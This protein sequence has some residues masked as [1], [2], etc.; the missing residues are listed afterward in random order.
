M[1]DAGRKDFSTKAKEEITPDSTKSTQQKI[2]EGVT[3]TTDRVARGTQPDSDKSAGQSAFDK[4]QRS[5]DEHVH[6][7]TGQSMGRSAHS[8]ALEED[9]K[10]SGKAYRRSLLRSRDNHSTAKKVESD[11]VQASASPSTV[12]PE[13]APKISKSLLSH[14]MSSPSRRRRSPSREVKQNV[15]YYR[16]GREGRKCIETFEEEADETDP[17]TDLSGFIV[18][19]DVELSVESDNQMSEEDSQWQ[20]QKNKD[21]GVSLRRSSH[22]SPRVN[23]RRQRSIPADQEITSLTSTLKNLDLTSIPKLNLTAVTN[24]VMSSPAKG[25]R[26]GSPDKKHLY[27]ER[28]VSTPE[29]SDNDQVHEEKNSFV[30]PPTSPSKPQLK[31]PSKSSRQIP[32]SPHKQSLDSFWSSEATNTWN[33]QHSPRKTPHTNR[34]GIQKFL[35]FSHDDMDPSERSTSPSPTKSCT[36][37]PQKWKPVTS[38]TK[39]RE[40]N[41]AAL[42]RRKAFDR[43]KRSLACDLLSELDKNVCQG[44]LSIATV[45]TGGVKVKW[46]KTLN[47]TAGRANWR[48]TNLG[49]NAQSKTTFAEI[50]LA[51][52][53]IDCPERLVNTLSHEFCHL[54][55]YEVSGELADAHGKSWR[56]WVKRALTYLQSQR[57]NPLYSKVEITTRHNYKIDYKYVWL[58]VGSGGVDL[59]TFT[60]EGCGMEYGRHSK[61]INPERQRQK[62]S[63]KLPSPRKKKNVLRELMEDVNNMSRSAETKIEVKDRANAGWVEVVDL[64]D[65]TPTAKLGDAGLEIFDPSPVKPEETTIVDLTESSDVD[66]GI[67][68]DTGDLADPF[69]IYEKQFGKKNVP[70]TVRANNVVKSFVL[71][72]MKID[73]VDVIDLTIE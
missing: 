66:D 23:A 26:T 25:K 16:Y 24:P 64:D 53:V 61:S 30:T 7:G 45:E 50:E 35:V 47:K 62:L 59:I 8:R 70:E 39:L 38:P 13:K 15:N 22:K 54:A 18:D 11:F 36:E 43:I 28:E 73:T 46:S 44:K 60:S 41:K 17:F 58:C 14:E 31:S 6:G 2:K 3:D 68:T 1:S 32:Q 9:S 55:N 40:T 27:R 49:P 63:E 48:R 71:G 67:D 4:T 34:K 42:E 56:M 10:M 65:N 51:E 72:K 5:S 29:P 20:R 33:D 69:T 57:H 21:R 19:D 52:K 12:S 37:S